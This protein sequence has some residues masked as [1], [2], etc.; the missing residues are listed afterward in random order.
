MIRAS[1]MKRSASD[2][3]VDRFGRKH[4]DRNVAEEVLVEGPQHGAQLA[5]RNHLA[6]DE[7]IGFV[8]DWAGAQVSTQKSS[9]AVMRPTMA[10]QA[11]PR[12]DLDPKPRNLRPS[13]GQACRTSSSHDTSRSR[14]APS[15]A[16]ADERPRDS[17]SERFRADR[18]GRDT[19][20]CDLLAT[21]GLHR[22]THEDNSAIPAS[23]SIRLGPRGIR[24][25]RS[26]DR[27]RAKN[28][29]ASG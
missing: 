28:S 10:T 8:K 12:Q 15:G 6:F 3:S 22:Q 18:P 14:S 24:T 2:R 9:V 26:G 17:V 21:R 27:I 4:L 1:S 5:S 19:S 7:P 23:S 20:G 11:W 29:D 13:R 25:S 16:L